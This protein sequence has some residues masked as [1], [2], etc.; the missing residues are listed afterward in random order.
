M[1]PDYH[2]EV[3]ESAFL[4]GRDASLYRG[5]IGSAN[6]MIT[7]GRFDIAYAVNT[8]ARYNMTPRQG[9]LDAMCRLFGYVKLHPQGQILVDPGIPDETNIEFVSQNWGEFYPDAEGELPPD[10]P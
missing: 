10:M 8:L 4:S 5:L 6:W 1:H 2:P 9:H 7:L 3:D